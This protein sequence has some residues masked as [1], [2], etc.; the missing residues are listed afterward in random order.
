MDY[1][2]RV[3]KKRAQGDIIYLSNGET[4]PFSGNDKIYGK[5]AGAAETRGTDISCANV[6][7]ILPAYTV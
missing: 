1:Y 3:L 4:C 2:G 7:M 5:R 6:G